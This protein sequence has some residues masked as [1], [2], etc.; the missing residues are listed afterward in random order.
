MYTLQYSTATHCAQ[1]AQQALAALQQQATAAYSVT[2][3]KQANSYYC[4]TVQRVFN[5]Y[6]S[7]VNTFNNTVANYC[8]TVAQHIDTEEYVPSCY[9]I[10]A[11]G[12]ACY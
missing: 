6:S 5:C 8:N 7:A 4:V 12:F 1:Q 2:L 9:V 11:E 3:V 10:D